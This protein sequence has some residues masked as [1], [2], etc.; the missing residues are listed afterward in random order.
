MIFGTEL[1][2]LLRV[3]LL[4]KVFLPT[5]LKNVRVRVYVSE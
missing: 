2:Q 5:L 3:F 1:S 4:L